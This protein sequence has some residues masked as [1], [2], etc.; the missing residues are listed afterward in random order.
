MMDITNMGIECS[1]AG[2]KVTV[3]VKCRTPEEIDDVVAWLGL[4]RTLMTT[5]KCYREEKGATDE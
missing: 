2:D 4:V 3:W 5:W 1:N